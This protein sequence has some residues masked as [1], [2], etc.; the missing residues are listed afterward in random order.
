MSDTSVAVVGLGVVGARVAR[1][2]TSSSIP[3]LVHDRRADLQNVTARALKAGE[4]DS[5]IDLHPG[6]TSVVVLAT[7]SRQGTLTRRLVERGLNVVCTSDDVEDV[8]DL[9]ELD[10]VARAN[11]VSI[12]VGAAA[13]PGLSGLLVAE[14]A[15]RVDVIDEIHVGV[16]GTGGPACARQH[17]RALAG[18]APGWH[19]GEWI[20]RPGGS[21]RELLWFPEPIG[22]RDC[23]RAE[24]ADPLT[25]QRAFPSA[26]RI[27]ARMSATRRD[28]LTARLP[29]MSPP[30]AEGGIGGVRVEIRG[31][32]GGER[33]TEVAGTAERTGIISGAMASAA[34]VSA[35][36]SALPVGVVVLGAPGVPNGAI[37]DDVI[38][39][40][41]TIFEYVGS[42][43]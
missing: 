10:G 22:G 24:L 31:S 25:L 41:I 18:D 28:R 35:L 43:V 21:G 19:D 39:R 17:H 38:K 12:V 37:L 23:Y 29:M 4:I 36:S 7:P 16:H 33:R 9:L 32:R 3:V 14:L 42:G 40:G 27:S 26:S 1:Q 2:L 11:N 8:R 15:S 13:S 30:H 20:S 5:A 6:E 34:A